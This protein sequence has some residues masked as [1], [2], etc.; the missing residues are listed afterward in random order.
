MERCGIVGL[1]NV[2]KSTLFNLLT[3]S[4]QARAEDFPFC[5]IDPNKAIVEV[6]DERLGVLSKIS[7]SKKIIYPS[8]EFFD[9][10]GLVEGAH[11][12]EGLGNKFLSHISQ[13]DLIIHVVRCFKGKITHVLDRV[14]PIKDFE[15]IDLELRLAD[16]Q[17]I[18]NMKK[19]RQNLQ[20]LDYAEKCIREEKY[21][22]GP[23]AN[24]FLCNKKQLILCNSDNNEYTEQMKE[25]LKDKPFKM[26][27]FD[28]SYMEMLSK[29]DPTNE[30]L[31]IVKDFLKEI[32]KELGLISFFTTGKEETRA[33]TIKQGDNALIAASKIHNDIAKKFIKAEVTPFE[34]YPNKMRLEGKD[35]IV[36]DSDVIVFKHNA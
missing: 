7:N 13:V 9:I 11:K 2:G 17:K 22:D 29:E 26:I 16:L 15:I 30:E 20:E 3:N 18:E 34:T 31:S 25:F 8:I 21:F 33:W 1:P 35:Y 12:G 28:I 36:K 27:N 23:F 24:E 32:Y 14:D 5:T 10:A 4:S 6:F 19:K